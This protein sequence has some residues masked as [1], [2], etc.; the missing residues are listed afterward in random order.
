MVDM[1][2]GGAMLRRLL[3]TWDPPLLEA[4]PEPGI[5]RPDSK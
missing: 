5:P 4:K 1:F 2:E 3:N